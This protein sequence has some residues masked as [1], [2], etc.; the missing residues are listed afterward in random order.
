MLGAARQLRSR[1]TK[2]S[3]S[4]TARGKQADVP[5]RKAFVS[6]SQSRPC[7]L[8]NAAPLTQN[9]PQGDVSNKRQ[10]QPNDSKK[11][12]PAAKRNTMSALVVGGVAKLRRSARSNTDSEESKEPAPKKRLTRKKSRD[13]ADP[14]ETEQGP[15]KKRKAT[16]K[17]GAVQE[18]EPVLAQ[19]ATGGI[20]V[21][22][23][24]DS[25]PRLRSRPREAAEDDEI[26]KPAPRAK[27]STR[28]APAERETKE[29]LAK[30]VKR[31][32][33]VATKPKKA[34]PKTSKPK[35][36]TVIKT[37][38]NTQPEGGKRHSRSPGPNQLRGPFSE[39]RV[40]C[41]DF[42]SDSNFTLVRVPFDASKYT[43]GFAKHDEKN[44]LNPL[45]VSNYATD[46]FQRLYHSEVSVIGEVC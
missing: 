38:D 20:N 42:V 33:A 8:S 5:K 18:V 35:A 29:P 24:E 45:Q 17:Q 3:T 44:R 36:A 4:A 2:A 11:A 12:K 28:T 22:E 1:G 46:L 39:S 32:T 7:Q 23:A 10:N 25:K 26:D 14:V 13:E 9:L 37:E 6:H 40:L 19:Q 30:R 15:S 34:V 27:R 16:R 43:A 21:E 41:S 31:A